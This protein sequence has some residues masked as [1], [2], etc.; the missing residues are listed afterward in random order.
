M[1]P[2]QNATKYG[3]GRRNTAK[4]PYELSY[5]VQI[6]LRLKSIASVPSSVLGNIGFS[7]GRVEERLNPVYQLP[8]YV[9]ATAV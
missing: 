2:L 8:D 9:C 4:R 5:L 1:A 7:R 3:S 6:W